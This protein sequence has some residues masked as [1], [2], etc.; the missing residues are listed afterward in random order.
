MRPLTFAANL[1][2]LSLL[3][4]A[5]QASA[6]NIA[7]CEVVLIETIE[8]ESGNG[9]AQIASYRPAADFIGSVYNNEQDVI[10]EL[11]GLAIRA[12]LCRRRNVIITQTDFKLLATGVPFILSQNFDSSESD[13]LTYFFKDGKFQYT[14]KG[15]KLSN[16]S[17]KTLDAHMAD[18]NS[19]EDTI[20]ALEEA[21]E[22]KAQELSTEKASDNE[23][24]HE[25]NVAI[26]NDV[27][28]QNKA[29]NMTENESE[30]GIE[31]VK[32]N[33]PG[34]S[35]LKKSNPSSLAKNSPEALQDNDNAEEGENGKTE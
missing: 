11:D 12:L 20:T 26:Q 15:R 6:D 1:L 33:I 5:P 35:K 23:A 25:G 13:L 19:R 31:I 3:M 4:A 32:L 29:Q 28:P 30:D 27:E 16:D 2:S 18:F 9:S 21:K 17:L 7:D 22:A 8:D 14:H 10:M 24:N 34:K